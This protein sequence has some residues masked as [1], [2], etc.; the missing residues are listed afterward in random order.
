MKYEYINAKLCYAQFFALVLLPVSAALLSPMRQAAHSFA[1]GNCSTKFIIFSYS[2]LCII[3]LRN[4]A[5]SNL[6]KAYDG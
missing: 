5:A 1:P 4:G 2:I 6:L 3:L